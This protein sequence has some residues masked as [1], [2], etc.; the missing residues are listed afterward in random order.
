LDWATKQDGI[1]ELDVDV[2]PGTPFLKALPVGDTQIV[3]DVGANRPDLLSHLGVAREVA[4]VT[5]KPLSLP[6]FPT[7]VRSRSLLR[8]APLGPR[9]R[10]R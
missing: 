3:L 7:S 6:C 5:G 10:R 9:M 2:P 1:L 8:R 4:G